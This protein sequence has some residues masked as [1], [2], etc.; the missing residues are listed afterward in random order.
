[1]SRSRRPHLG[2]ALAAILVL[3]AGPAEA[4]TSEIPDFQVTQILGLGELEDELDDRIGK[5]FGETEHIINIRDCQ[6]YQG[7]E[8]EISWSIG[9]VFGDWTWGAAYSRA[10]ST[11]KADDS[12]FTDEDDEKCRITLQQGET[13][14]GSTGAFDIEFDFLTGGNCNAG[15]DQNA[16]AYVV[17]EQSGGTG[18]TVQVEEIKFEVDLKPPVAP[19]LAEVSGGDRRI[20]VDWDDDNNDPEDTSYIVYYSTDPIPADPPDDVRTKDDVEDTSTSL[21][22]GVVNGVTFYVRVAAEDEADNIGPL[23][24]ELTVVPVETEDFWE[25]YLAAG[26]TEEGGFC[27]VATAAYGTPMAGDLDALRA[28]RDQVLLTSAPGQAFVEAYYT[29]GRFAAAWIAD[30]PTVRAATRVALVPL[31]WLAHLTTTLPPLSAAAVVLMGLALLA[32]ASRRL[33]D[34]I[35]RDV[36]LEAR[37]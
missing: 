14:N 27:F 34:H 16:F 22:G 6:D 4:Q 17:F 3:A 2:A 24:E 35:L 1:M 8:A 28:F 21:T 31:V 12:S 7:G 26:G 30:K 25:Q 36:P 20:E 19:V 15:T 23:S 37:R 33:R 5:S 32:A 13:L 11:C 29:W 9:S 18:A 10:G